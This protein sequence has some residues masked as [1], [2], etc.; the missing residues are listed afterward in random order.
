MDG[1]TGIQAQVL[2]AAQMGV[3]ARVRNV[4]VKD[5]ERALWE[6]RDLVKTW[7]MRGT[8]HFLPARELPTYLGGLRREIL[9]REKQWMSR[10]GLAEEDF[11]RMTAA[12]EEALASGPL[13]RTE[14]SGAVVDRLGPGARRWIEHG[15]GGVVRL[16]C[17]EG[18]VCFGPNNGREITFARLDDWL[19]GLEDVSMDAAET[20]L[21]RRY[22][23]AH[24]PAIPQDYAYWTGMR[25]GAAKAIWNRIEDDLVPVDVEGRKGFLLRDDAEALPPARE[26]DGAVRLL[27]Y[28]DGYLLA[29]RDKGHLVDEAHFKRVY[30]KAGWISPSVLVAGRVAGTWSHEVTGSRLRVEVDPFESY[31]KPVRD[32]VEEE[33]AALARFL[34]VEDHEVAVG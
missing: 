29:H 2:S 16:A 23:R 24:G 22:L 12:V 20:A 18:R 33:V 19:P 13:T 25:V 1:A 15:W 26:F 17:V 11:P 8:L 6:T 28:F 32:G 21:L 31:P 27:P 14:L 9:R 10:Y 5:V 3:G 30:R 7:A 4:S 34:E